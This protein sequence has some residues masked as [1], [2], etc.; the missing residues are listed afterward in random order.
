MSSASKF[1]INHSH[2]VVRECNGCASIRR[3]AYGEDANRLICSRHPY[4][5]MQFLLCFCEDY[6]ISPRIRELISLNE[7]ILV[8]K[9]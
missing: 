2:K 1:Y 6:R 8:T 7:N 5:N 3:K 4:P 9:G